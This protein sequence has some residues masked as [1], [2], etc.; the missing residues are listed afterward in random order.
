MALADADRAGGKHAEAKAYYER[1]LALDSSNA[2]AHLDFGNLLPLKQDLAQ[3]LEAVQLDPDSAAAQ[4]S[5]AGAE[6]DSGE[7]AQALIPAQALMRLDPTSAD[8]AMGLA[9]VYS[10]LHRDAEA[11]KAFDIVQPDTELAKA[12]IAAGRLTYQSVLDPKLHAKALAVVDALRKRSD[13]D[14]DSMGNVMEFELALG[15]NTAALEQLP[16]L[17]ASLWFACNDLSVFPLWIPL[18][19]NP[20]FEA[21]V[22]QYDTTSKPAPA[23]APGTTTPG[24]R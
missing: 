12:L 16:K 14:P 11:V 18:H 13:L 22:K 5:L 15:E 8:S 6:L 21:L 23:S 10:L 17:C 20:R 24:G 2:V 7:Y 1:A 19:G 3:T 9:L 4:N